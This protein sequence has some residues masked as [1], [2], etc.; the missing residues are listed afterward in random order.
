MV[1]GDRTEAL[2]SVTVPML[3]IHGWDDTLIDPSGREATAAVVPGASL[4]MLDDMGHDLPKPLWP[5][6]VNAIVE[7][8]DSATPTHL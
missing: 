5:E 2:K 7:F 1:S 6:I 4:L 8:G 3:V